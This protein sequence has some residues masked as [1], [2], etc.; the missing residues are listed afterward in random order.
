MVKYIIVRFVKINISIGVFEYYMILW[1]LWSLL[2]DIEFGFVFIR[3]V[4]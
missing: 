1:Y 2:D 4:G 3:S